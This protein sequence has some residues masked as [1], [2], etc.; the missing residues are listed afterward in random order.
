M[1]IRLKNFKCYIDSTYELGQ[2]GI[3]LISGPSGVGKSS[4]LEGVYFAL[5]GEGTRIIHHGKNNCE[6]ILSMKNLHISRKKRPNVLLVNHKFHDSEGEEIIKKHIHFMFRKIGY[7]KQNSFQSFLFMSPQEKLKFIESFTI[8]SEQIIHLKSVVD[9]KIKDICQIDKT[10]TIQ[11][12]T[13]QTILKKEKDP[14]IIIQN[15]PDIKVDEIM[16]D[17][18]RNK[19]EDFQK[20]EHKII[21]TLLCIKSNKER[22]DKLESEMTRLQNKKS[23]LIVIK[24]PIFDTTESNIQ[25]LESQ[26]KQLE[27]IINQ[28]IIN[29]GTINSLKDQKQS[30]SLQLQKELDNLNQIIFKKKP[31][32]MI[33]EKDISNIETI[34]NETES[35]IEETNNS[36]QQYIQN[37][38]IL[39]EQSKLLSQKI[40]KSDNLS[41][42]LSNHLFKKDLYSELQHKI[43]FIQ[44]HRDYI[45]LVK[46]KNNK[47]EEFRQEQEK[48][49]E[50]IKKLK[51]EKL[52]KVSK[53]ENDTLLYNLQQ[54]LEEWINSEKIIESHND[55]ETKLFQNKN[56]LKI[57]Q[58]LII[59]QN[60]KQCPNCKCFLYL[61]SEHNL[62]QTK[63]STMIKTKLNDTQKLI[64]QKK[65]L[66]KIKE[67]LEKK[68]ISVEKAKQTISQLKK[69]FTTSIDIEIKITKIKQIIKDE[70]TQELKLNE[71]NNCLK[72]KSG[73]LKI[74]QHK[75]RL[76]N[77]KISVYINKFNKLKWDITKL[78]KKKIQ[79]Q[80][81]DQSRYREDY[82]NNKNILVFIQKE[83]KTKRQE[84][85]TLDK[86]IKNDEKYHKILE[87]LNK[88]RAY[89]RKK[90]IIV[91]QEKKKTDEYC[92]FI[93][94][95]QY[96]EKL[97]LEIKTHISTI[98]DKIDSIKIGKSLSILNKELSNN[99]KMIESHKK[100]LN[101]KQKYKY[102][103]DTKQNI[104]YDIKQ[105][106]QE[107][108]QLEDKIKDKSELESR[109]EI[110][111]TTCLKNKQLIIQLT[112]TLKQWNSYHS[113]YKYKS[114]IETLEKEI[115]DIT[116]NETLNRIKLRNHELF[117]NK[118]EEAENLSIQSCIELLNQ[119]VQKYIHLF[120]TDEP[121]L[122]KINTFRE[123]KKN[124]KPYI[125]ISIDYKGCS[126][127]VNNLS[128]G[129][130]SRVNIAFI[131]A[132]AEI[133]QFPF[134]MLDESVSSLDQHTTSCIIDALHDHFPNTLILLIAHQV[135]KGQF[136]K[137]IN[138]E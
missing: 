91:K 136:N 34:I 122:L 59:K 26:Q 6:V 86:S 124:K 99:K 74:L 13:L 116:N 64:E 51:G 42:L 68:L 50:N 29:K 138:I 20:E 30:F 128:G 44:E 37:K 115:K 88:K 58:D 85:Q 40:E 22:I 114:K 111:K 120:F 53:K 94:Q 103:I 1:K 18:I 81:K 117:K 102:Y 35:S 31:E 11:K 55:I 38:A 52:N 41:N 100:Q 56:R 82:N 123:T 83:V 121:L 39:E 16:I 80:F 28:T 4:I 60:I 67:N 133:Y 134:I 92:N 14:N 10:F 101:H 97:I 48:I 47:L 49:K 62:E 12:N 7:M 132:F 119:C 3:T 72:Q 46:Q 77:D 65:K 43:E 2:Q 8:D 110:I 61:N 25:R 98:Q 104:D 78:D 76:I 112:T 79:K 107:K 87:N 45:N 95:Q 57:I 21:Q 96:H 73:I 54:S 71:L 118:I 106:N 66:M 135:V 19:I 126:T 33:F 137:I 84:I 130:Q 15:K 32:K 9:K 127:T 23:K 17:N 27:K 113:Y 90:I 129:E 125:S 36:I 131:L 105:F 108:K 24:P 5:Y 69:K 109:L 75:I 89:F 93:K 70:Q 63:V